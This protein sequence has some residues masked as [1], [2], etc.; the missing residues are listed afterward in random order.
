VRENLGLGGSS[1]IDVM[2]RDVDRHLGVSQP[3][4][5]RRA[6][7][8][9]WLPLAGVLAGAVILLVAI[10]IQQ[11]TRTEPV[12]GVVAGSVQLKHRVELSTPRVDVVYWSGVFTS[13]VDHTQHDVQLDADNA[14]WNPGYISDAFWNPGTLD[15]VFLTKPVR[16]GSR[17]W[18]VITALVVM[19]A[20]GTAAVLVAEGR[21]ARGW[22]AQSD[23]SDDS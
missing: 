18:P 21:P 13:S 10:E 11:P 14:A 23:P 12:P 4:P 17:Q 7:I 1:T 8:R 6:K 22:G 2:G 5:T 19:L 15:V 9:R 20:I 3:R 16:S